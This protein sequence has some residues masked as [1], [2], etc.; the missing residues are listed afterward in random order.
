[1]SDMIKVLFYVRKSKTTTTGLSP[2]YLRVTVDGQRFETASSRFIEMSK[3]SQ[4]AGKAIGSTKEAKELNEFLNVLRAKAFDIQKKLI[5]LGVTIT[6]EIFSKQWHG[7]KEKPRMLLE[8]FQHHNSQVK[9]LI[10]QQYSD[11]T[12]KRYETSLEHTRKFIE[13]YFSVSDLPINQL[14]YQFITDYEFWLKTKRNCNHNSTIKYLTNFK[15]IIHICIKNAWLDRDPF[16]GYKMTKREVERPYLTQEEID[17]ISNKKIL[18][19]R[20]NQVRDI[21]L[22]CCYTGLAYV[23]VKK[24]SRSEISVGIDGEKWI[25]TH[26][27]KTE[28]ATRIPLLPKAR[29]ILEKYSSHPQ[30]L[31]QDRLLPVLSN[32]KM[33]SYLEEIADLCR[34]TK[35]MTMHTARHTFAT[36]VTLTNGVPIE[37]VGKMLGHKN[38]RTT[39]HYAKILDLKVSQDMNILRS[40]MSL[41]Q[42]KKEATGT[43]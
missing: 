6:S 18:V 14:N 36:T 43:E 1:M 41:P 10:G 2:I 20:I 24:L 22:F 3:W 42:I 34:I 31:S 30:C 17:A 12:F 40:R 38:L 8:I 5:T 11:S 32:Q 33:N 4:D 25:F 15:K 13:A 21:F 16:V 35:N 37:T 27:Q 9:E 29:E 7:V 39:Q 23:D 26:R 28:T 19:P